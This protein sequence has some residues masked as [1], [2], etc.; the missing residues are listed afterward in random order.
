MVFPQ[1]MMAVTA[2]VTGRTGRGACP[3]RSPSCS[4]R[5]HDAGHRCRPGRWASRRRAA[6]LA[7][8]TGHSTA[9]AA[10][11]GQVSIFS[12]TAT[13]WSRRDMSI[14]PRPMRRPAAGAWSNYYLSLSELLL[15]AP[16]ADAFLMVQDDV[17]FYDRQDLRAYLEATLWPTD[18]PGL[19]SLY[20]SAGYSREG[21]GWHQLDEPWSWA[22]WPLSSHGLS[23]PGSLP[24]PMY[25]HTSG[26]G[27]WRPR[28][29]RASM[30]S[31]DAGPRGTE[32]RS[33]IP[34]RASPSI[35]GISA[36]CGPLKGL[37]ASPAQTGSLP[38]SSLTEGLLRAVVHICFLTMS[39][40]A[41]AWPAM[42]C[43]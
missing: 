41:K 14:C 35:P 27:H 38:T 15:R 2:A 23:L 31:S 30:R 4:R 37:S 6:P 33:I 18:P 39:F 5:C 7:R 10:P 20:C 26:R 34:A 29:G 43:A 8:S 32:S 9:S 17:L 1:P 40:A 24:I 21:A 22:C 25:A 36:S 12:R 3:D 16:A 13:S 28:A 11:A 42:S 19:V